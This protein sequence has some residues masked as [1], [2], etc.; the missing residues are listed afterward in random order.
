MLIFFYSSRFHFEILYCCDRDEGGGTHK[1]F[2]QTRWWVVASMG[3]REIF[4][5]KSNVGLLFRFKYQNH[6]ENLI[7]FYNETIIN[8]LN[9]SSELSDRTDEFSSKLSW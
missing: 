7:S 1:L 6:F 9:S 4:K 8:L 2:R 5:A 3:G